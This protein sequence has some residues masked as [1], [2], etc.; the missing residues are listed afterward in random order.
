MHRL[1]NK[2]MEYIIKENLTLQLFKGDFGLEKENVRVDGQGK[3]A[4]TPH[5][6]EFG[7][8]LYNPYIKTDF[9]ES[10]IEMI[11]PVCGT[12]EEAYSFLE[13]L[14]DI[15]SLNIGDEYLW[16]QSNPPIL[17]EEEAIPI[18][19]FESEGKSQSEYRHRLAEK[20]GRKKQMLS[21]IH[22]NF[23]FDEDFL[24]I[25]HEQFG[26]KESYRS[27]KD[28]LYL[29]V[30]RNFLRHRWLLIYLTGASPVF[31]KTY[32]ENFEAI[33]EALGSDCL[34]FKDLTSLRNSQWGYKNEEDFI[35]S[36]D[37]L[38]GYIKDVQSLIDAGKIANASEFY[39][40]VRLKAKGQ[41]GNLELL[42][43]E[44]IKYLELRIFDLNPLSKNGIFIEDV[45]LVHLFMIY[46]LL[47]EDC[48]FGAKEQEIANQNHDIATMLGRQ[49]DVPIYNEAR[50]LVPLREVALDILADLERIIEVLN[51]KVDLFTTLIDSSKAKVK[52][53]T[54]T[55]AQR[56]IEAVREQ[57]YVDFHLEIAKEYLEDSSSKS[58]LCGF[59][60][61][62]LSTQILIRD[63]ITRG[64]S[65]EILDREENFL[66]LTQGSKV[67]YVK[68]ATK[69]SKDSYI[70]YLIMENKVV[71]KELLKEQG[72]TVPA[73]LSYSSIDEAKLSFDKFQGAKIVIKPKSTNYGIG[74]SIFKEHFT[75]KEF[76]R[77]LEIAFRYDQTVLVEHFAPGKEYRFLVIGNEVVGVLQR[78]PA[79]VQGDGHKNIRELVQVKNKDPL[80]GQGH[81]TPL[82][83]I[84]L[85][86]IEEG[87]LKSQGKD[88]DYI[89]AQGEVV[90]LRENSNISTGGDSI[91]YTDTVHESYKQLALKAAQAVRA[92]ITGVDIMIQDINK[93][94]DDSNYAIIELNFN[95]AMYMHYYPYQGKRRPVGEKV[96][97]LLFDK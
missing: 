66:K 25:L 50:Q 82:E 11:T 61:L 59:E 95:P 89:P 87:F 58:T 21:G 90:F 22:Y 23:S 81:K 32:G 26:A 75:K 10:Q 31:H 80:R 76:D 69:T 46:M 48:P 79:N 20:Y 35:V 83:K 60:D 33:S 43:D 36:Y 24:K 3:L 91:D 16:P 65:F 9:S 86:E 63:A 30:A 5:P 49:A 54:K 56:I 78:V 92:N 77:A 8:K 73:S 72:L 41:K 28:A 27:F 45:Y 53:P 29:K 13:N 52:D 85:G 2:L 42:K 94:Y 55:Y 15:V 17:P 4:L 88:F 57:S 18:A 93:P 1:D 39:N 14:Q 71:T 84:A 47:L 34:Y 44:G 51:T 6:E 37:S 97:S 96:L 67:E 40:P 64:I 7:S 74:I 70:S 12:I 62:E 68:Q 19:V 38:A